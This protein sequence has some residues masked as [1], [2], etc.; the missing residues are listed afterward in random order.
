MYCHRLPFS[1]LIEL[2]GTISLWQSVW[3]N[4]VR[5][6][7]YLNQMPAVDSSI[8]FEDHFHEISPQTS[9]SQ[10]I[11]SLACETFLFLRKAL[12]LKL[13]GDI[14]RILNGLIAA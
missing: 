13:C 12:N 8:E 6:Y 5:E 11:V 7:D 3:T 9:R 4:H 2:I 10:T 1:G 14:D